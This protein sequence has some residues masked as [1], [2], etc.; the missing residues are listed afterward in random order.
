MFAVFIPGIAV[1]LIAGGV[2]VGLLVLF[3]GGV[4]EPVAVMVQK[5]YRKVFRAG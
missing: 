2:M 1:Y 5:S 3:V 4:G